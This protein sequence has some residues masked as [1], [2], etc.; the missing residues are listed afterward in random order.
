MSKSKE[1]VL[2]VWIN[3]IKDD[4]KNMKRVLRRLQFVN[5]ETVLSKGQVACIL[6]SSD[7]I[8]LTE[9]LFNGAF[10]DMEPKMLCAMLS[11]FLMNVYFFYNKGK[12]I[13]RWYK[14][15]KKS[16]FKHLLSKD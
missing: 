2:K 12:Y 13:K 14:N 4:L 8:L 10:N 5:D 15:F 16:T 6:T 7:E 3:I 9:M 1:I 11:C